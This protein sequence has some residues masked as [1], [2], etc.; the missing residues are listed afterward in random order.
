MITGCGY[1][2]T[3]I[4]KCSRIDF[5][6][7]LVSL[8]H[9]S[10][11]HFMTLVKVCGITNLDDALA[12]ERAGA[13]ALGFNF[14][15]GSPRYLSPGEARLIIEHL[16]E[17]ILC[18][19]VFVD[20]DLS[21]TVARMA[22]EAGVSAV[23]LHGDESPAY[24]QALEGLTVIKAL[25]VGPEFSPQDALRYGKAVILLD[26]YCPQARGGTG[27]QFDWSLARRTRELVG[28]LYL[29]GGLTPENVA[30]AIAAVRPY[31]ID[32]CSGVESS[33]GKKNHARMRALINVA[34][35]SPENP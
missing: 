33:P 28:K 27:Q 31:A 20:E 16:P 22:G 4:T 25:R 32:V 14:Y 29:A 24:C 8:F 1:A 18:V 26:A 3:A 15:R 5:E 19:G 30:G 7:L 13:G 11:F 34:R 9:V 10:P 2:A 35:A 17:T 6:T 21:T 12:S 23:Q